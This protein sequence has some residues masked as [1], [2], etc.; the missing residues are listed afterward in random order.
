MSPGINVGRVGPAYSPDALAAS[1]TPSIRCTYHPDTPI[2]DGREWLQDLRARGISVLMVL[3]N[4][5]HFWEAPQQWRDGI[6]RARN[7]YGDLV[8]VWQVCNE[9]DAGWIPGPD[10][11]TLEERAANHPSS[12]VMSQAELSDRLKVARQVLGQNAVIIGPGLSSG[13][14]GWAAGDPDNGIPPVD[15]SSVDMLGVHAYLKLPGSL[16]LMAMLAA[17]AAYG[18]PL[19]ITEYDA[20]TQGMHTWM[21]ANM[22]AAWAFCWSNA[23]HPQHGLIE[24]PDA[25][26]EFKA[27]N[28]ITEPEEP[29]AYTVGQ[30]VLD[31][32]KMTGDQP[33][34]DEI[35]HPIGAAQGKHQYSETF[36]KSGTRYVYVFDT[37]TTYRFSP[38]R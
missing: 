31:Q 16:E 32:M 24:R 17:Y 6:A 14:A 26:A 22:G 37:N 19:A 11:P 12:W 8:D 21:A 9:P 25:Y 10:C 13:H 18:W 5:T 4:D 2:S 23:M 29:M 38:T 1:G 36:G 28:Q 33:A 20:T 3:D 30:G 35:Y 34:T 27:A 7:T 15:W